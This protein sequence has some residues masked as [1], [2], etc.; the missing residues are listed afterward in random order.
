MYYD[1]LCRFLI[2]E[3]SRD[4]AT[5]FMGKPIELTILSPKELSVEPI[6]A[7]SLILLQSED[8]VL[9]IEFQTN[10]EVEIPFPMADY[11]LRV[12]TLSGKRYAPGGDL[13]QKN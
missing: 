2:D 7:D 4:F 1:I 8:S 6:R 9:H 13:P 11:R 5:L 10:P 12:S 3:F